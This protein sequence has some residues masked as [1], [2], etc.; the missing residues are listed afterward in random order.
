MKKD[1]FKVSK[2]ADELSAEQTRL[3]VR[4]IGNAKSMPQANLLKVKNRVS[5]N[6]LAGR[7]AVRVIY[8]VIAE[9]SLFLDIDLCPII[10]TLRM[11]S[12]CCRQITLGVVFL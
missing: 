2:I 3:K 11:A 9:S 12:Q 7:V 5:K 4:D 6:I 10:E 8:S 1:E